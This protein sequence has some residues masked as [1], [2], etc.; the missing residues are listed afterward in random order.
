MLIR[1]REIINRRARGGQ[2][3]VTGLTEARRGTGRAEQRAPEAESEFPLRIGARGIGD[4]GIP[5]A[6]P[7][8]RPEEL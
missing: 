5:A 6:I 2:H 4:G 7:S 8:A 3:E 1:G